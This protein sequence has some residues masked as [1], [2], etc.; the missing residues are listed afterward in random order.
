MVRSIFFCAVCLS[1]VASPV[2]G[3]LVGCGNHYSAGPGQAAP[4]A[5][6][7]IDGGADAASSGGDDGGP[8]GEGGVACIEGGAGPKGNQLVKS[9]TVVILGL[10][11]DDQVVYDETSSST[12]FAVPAGG[13]SPASIGPTQGSS[14]VAIASK[15]VFNWT[16]NNADGTVG[17]L[18]TWTALGGPQSLA[19][20][21]LVG[22]ADSSGDGSRV[23]YFDGATAS[24]A[25]LYM[26]Q[27][28]GSGKTKLAA[29]VPWSPSCVPQVVFVGI[30]PLLA[31]CPEGTPTDPTNP[32]GTV[33]LF[34]GASTTS[35]TLSTSVLLPSLDTA[36]ATILFRAA[37]GLV[38]ASASS[39]VTTVLDAAGTSATFTHDGQSVVYVTSD[40]SLKTTPVS[41]PNPTT[42]VAGGGFAA[43]SSTSPDDRWVL[44]SKHVDPNTGNLDIYIASATA[45]GSATAI[46]ETPTGAF[47]GSPFTADSS[48]VLYVDN[49][50]NG[51]G[52]YYVAPM[53]GGAGVQ[54]ASNMWLGLATNG[55][56]VVFDDGFIPN[57]GLGQ[58]GI[59]DIESMDVSVAPGV[60]TPLVN[61]ADPG[62]FFTSGGDRLVYSLT[63]CA[64]GSQGIWMTPT[65]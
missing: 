49:T 35:T 27:S 59:A 25:D 15:A 33:S 4:G 37:N 63:Y 12:L 22:T 46:L 7:S 55:S 13:G 10:T 56:A 2:A 11:D 47:Y 3:A 31:Y 39:G 54:I 6:S 61:Q 40:G 16:A 51:A 23:L 64:T 9:A 65:P 24:S 21:S 19:T 48:R 20:A 32:V 14:A 26:A 42:L 50:A 34:V 28:D 5:S 43:V 1:F 45:P 30:S 8:P 38:V 53:T 62:L 41:S 52:D 29:G 58:Q 17:S 44:A 57:V 60:P 18:Q 36:G